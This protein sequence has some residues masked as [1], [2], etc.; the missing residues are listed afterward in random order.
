[1]QREA[2]P[3]LHLHLRLP[4]SLAI[5]YH[6]RQVDFPFRPHSTMIKHG[7]E[8]ISRH[9]LILPVQSPFQGRVRL[10]R[11]CTEDGP[12][13]PQAPFT[14][15]IGLEEDLPRW[16]VR[17]LYSLY[18]LE[19]TLLLGKRKGDDQ[20][21]DPSVMEFPY[22]AVFPERA[23]FLHL[24]RLLTLILTVYPLQCI[25][26][27]VERASSPLTVDLVDRLRAMVEQDQRTRNQ[28]GRHI[29]RHMHQCP[30]LV[31]Q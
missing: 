26:Q 1:M 18:R 27:R 3:I 10:A 25:D 21:T 17:A 4:V 24:Y 28:L 13:P 6:R 15:K 7:N 14:V 19:H 11:L 8:H 22:P 20:V 23:C 29:L 31:L 5:N 16:K 9:H 30:A 2:E 12:Q